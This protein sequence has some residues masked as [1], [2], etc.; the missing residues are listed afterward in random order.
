MKR[1]SWKIPN[2]IERQY[3]RAMRSM[4]TQLDARLR[5]ITDPQ[6]Q[7]RII[8]RFTENRQFRTYCDS[9]ARSMTT[10]VNGLT[11]RTWR[12]AARVAGRGDEMYAAI[13]QELKNNPHGDAFINMVYE[14]ASFIKTFPLEIA[15]ELNDFVMDETLKGRRASEIASDLMAKYSDISESRINLIARTEVAK[16]QSALTQARA[17]SLGIEWY[18]WR[19]SNDARVRNAHDHMHGVLVRWDD[20]PS[21]EALAPDAEQKPYGSYHAGNTFNCRCYPEPV[22]S[23]DFLEFPMKV[24]QNGSISYRVTRAQFEK[25]A[26]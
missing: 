17:E 20:P 6:E 2:R 8:R 5:G 13:L 1:N 16:T 25:L 22:V 24:Y 14:N 7:I 15:E 4:M 23:I 26:A 21:P 11:A 19:T 10:Q 3:A 18:V 9:L 12:E